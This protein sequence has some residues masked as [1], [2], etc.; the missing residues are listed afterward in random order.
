[1]AQIPK[2]L[3][4]PQLPGLKKIHDGKVRATYA[5]GMKTRL[6]QLA[7][8]RVSI[9]NFLLG[10]KV[11]QK[12]EILTAL[13]VF[14]LTEVLKQF[15]SH[16]V[17]YGSGISSYLSAELRKSYQ[18][19][20]LQKR[21]LIIE[22]LDLA[23]VEAIIRFFLTG[24]GWESFQQ[25]G[26]CYGHPVPEGAWNGM[27]LPYAVFTPTEKS[28]TDPWIHHDKVAELYGSAIERAALQIAMVARAHCQSRGL[29]L[30]DTKFELD[31]KGKIGDE[32]LTP[33]SSRIVD[34]TERLT[35][36]G[37]KKLATPLDKQFVRNWGRDQGMTELDPDNRDHIA[38]VH[39]MG[40]PADV[41][42]AT[43]QIYRY[44]FW[45]LTGKKLENFQREKM[46]IAGTRPPKLKIGV[47]IGSRSDLKQC[48]KGLHMLT[49][50]QREGL[51]DLD[52]NIISC[53]RNSGVLSAYAQLTQNDLIV[54][55]AGMAAALPG[56]LQAL[57]KASGKKT[58]VL[59]VA[60]TG[61]N[62]HETMAARLSIE[63]LP[64]KPVILDSKGQ[65]FS[66]PDGFASACDLAVNGEF[67]PAKK[68]EDRPAELN[69]TDF[70]PKIG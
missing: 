31:R 30:L 52:V 60:F 38:K 41:A 65:A 40:L 48:D 4:G 43:A 5:I 22:K 54:A 14:W 34:L 51:I 70:L 9:F 37:N 28:E 19:Q 42:E 66:G 12:G 62:F 8:D 46:Q 24:S 16:L 56:I 59:G 53:H 1:M 25:T 6:M 11:P 49:E 55:G 20:E 21:V 17:A 44:V 36:A 18:L 7:T 33:D 39:A 35:M 47:V 23:P 13:T 26:K 67:L 32:I 58:R 29:D 61:K 64:G 2:G 50:S 10:G 69:I 3:E 68:T 15:P 63:E 27:E 57:L 45:R